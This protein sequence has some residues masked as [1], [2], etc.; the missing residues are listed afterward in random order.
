MSLLS[1]PDRAAIP[2]PGSR[3]ICKGFCQRRPPDWSS[4][5][6][7]RLV[8]IDVEVEISV[9]DFLVFAV[10][11]NALDRRVDLLQQSGVALADASADAGPENVLV[12]G[13]RALA[14]A[15]G[16]ALI[17]FQEIVDPDRIGLGRIDAACHQ[18]LIGLVLRLVFPD[19]G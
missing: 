1:W 18:I 6:C 13:D 2:D 4:A 16:L 10:L 17:G 5:G 9:A 3:F 7:L 14:L 11:A 12:R 19:F 8:A 15:A